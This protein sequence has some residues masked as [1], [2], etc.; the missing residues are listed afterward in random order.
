M[1]PHDR[2]DDADVDRMDVS[3]IIVLLQIQHIV[4]DIVVLQNLVED[5]IGH[6]VHLF[7]IHV[8]GRPGPS[9]ACL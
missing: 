8:S 9:P 2:R 6:H 3:I 4:D 1:F 5:N 7:Q